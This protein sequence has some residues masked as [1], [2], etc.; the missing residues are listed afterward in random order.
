MA[1]YIKIEERRAKLA[2]LSGH[3]VTPPDADRIGD[4]LRGLFESRYIGGR[5]R[6]VSKAQQL[7]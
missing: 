1:D 4:L 2:V 3:M 5:G 6:A 7:G